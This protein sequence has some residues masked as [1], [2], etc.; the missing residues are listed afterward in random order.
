MIPKDGEFLLM[1]LVYLITLI[2][3]ILG[4]MFKSNKKEF[5]IHLILFSLYTGFMIVV[6][7]DEDSF[8]GG[9]SLVVLFYGFVFPIIHILIYGGIKLMISIRKGIIK[10]GA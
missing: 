2:L 5:W 8:S 7:S 9:A 3:I 10:K 6:F 1:Y 4:V